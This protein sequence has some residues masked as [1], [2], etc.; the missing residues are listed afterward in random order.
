MF[1]ALLITVFPQIIAGDDYFF[2]RIR[3]G[4][5]SREAVINIA[6]WKSCPQYFVLLIPLNKKKIIT[7]NK[8]NMG[9]QICSKFVSLILF[10]A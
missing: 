6:H 2:F 5:Y 4:D 9:F 1:S 10:R 7:S 8:L 3:R